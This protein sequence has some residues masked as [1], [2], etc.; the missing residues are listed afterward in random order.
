MQV[1]S[2]QV[3]SD[4][5]SCDALVRLGGKVRLGCHALVR[6]GGKVRLG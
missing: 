3:R 5:D 1:R 6:L 2:G 4:G